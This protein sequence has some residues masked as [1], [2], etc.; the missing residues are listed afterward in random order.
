V[1]SPA[2]STAES[3]RYAWY[4]VGVL[5]LATILSY[6]DRQILSLVVDPL[7]RDLS[8]SDTDV[9]LLLG[10]AFAVVYGLAGLPFGH[11]ADRRSRR[12]LIAGGIAAWSVGTA[13][14]GLAG[15]FGALFAARMV[16]GVGEAV[17]TPAAV[18]LI[19][20]YFP[21]QRR[22]TATGVFLMGIAIGAG[23][24]IFFGG[25]VLGAVQSGA[26]AGTPLAA[27]PA[28]RAVIV[29]LGAGG[30]VPLALLA[31][32]REP[33]RRTEP[34]TTSAPAA[35]PGAI[36]WP[37]LAPLLF[38]VATISLVDNAVLAWAPTRLIRD[39]GVEPGWLGLVLGALLI[40]GGGAGVL[41]GG[42]AG[43]AVRARLGARGP[44]LV[45]LGAALVTAPLA[46]V[47]LSA[48]VPVVL[49]SI[50][51][52]VLCSGVGTAAGIA[53]I[54][55][56]VPHARRGFATAVS[57][58]LNV[59]L[60]AGVGPPA[61]ALV[62]EHVVGPAAGLGPAIASVWM[63]GFGIVAGCFVLSLRSA[64]RGSAD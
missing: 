11:L 38:G 1:T 47:S 59:A 17:L 9:G 41:A 36:A 32:V 57:F 55:D 46:L 48:T 62:A 31:T 39:F 21:P 20:D 30:L 7:R 18:S 42:F 27:L 50:A 43:D 33:P 28:W 26:F 6:T 52:Y 4:V 49:A 12:G 40:A 56:A 8:I 64:P 19:S 14:C 25:L 34:A 35:D 58:F 3:G 24:A 2:T 23:G 54:L 29:M 37:R 61:V 15:S 60:G 22:G 45:C 13:A 10:T 44:R 63:A 53:A 51:L 16:V 5:V